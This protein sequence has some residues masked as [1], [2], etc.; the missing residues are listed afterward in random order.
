MSHNTKVYRKQGGDEMVVASGGKITI[1]SGGSIENA[2]TTYVV[3]D[4]DDVTLEVNGDDELA[5]K[6][7]GVGMTQLASAVTD[8]LDIIDAIPTEDPESAGVIWNDGGVLKV[9]AGS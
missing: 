7:G 2:G 4:P 5:I 6:D 9:S 1:E 8:L 3:T